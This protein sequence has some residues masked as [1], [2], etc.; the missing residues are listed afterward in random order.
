MRLRNKCMKWNVV[1]PSTVKNGGAL[2]W[3]WE[4]FLVRDA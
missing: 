1:R 4:D 3:L 2:E